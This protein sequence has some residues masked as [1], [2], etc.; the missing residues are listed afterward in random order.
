MEGL[1]NLEGFS[2]IILLYHYHLSR[3]HTLKVKPFL[4]DVERGLFA[5]EFDARKAERTGWLEKKAA[6]AEKI[7]ANGRFGD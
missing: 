4:D 3:A 5:P 7:S 1:Q 6:N 2:H